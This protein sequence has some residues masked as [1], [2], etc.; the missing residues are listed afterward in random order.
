MKRLILLA[1]GAAAAVVIALSGGAY[2]YWTSHGSGNGTSTVGTLQ[3]VTLVDVTGA[4]P[5][6]S[7]VPGG[8]ADLV[9][10]VNNQNSYSVNL[11]SVALK[12]GGTVTADGG[13]A[14][15][16]TT[17]VSV[18]SPTNLP[19]TLTPGTNVVHLTSGVSMS[20]ASVSACQGSTFQ[21]P[22]TIEVRK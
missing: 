8:T 18:G 22:V 9:L 4:S 11:F 10:R 17:G 7:L 19:Y 15:C 5:S 14:G 20:T 3:P 2:A 12:S 16:T 21:I 1:V 6:S 13:H